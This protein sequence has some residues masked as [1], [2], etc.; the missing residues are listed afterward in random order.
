MQVAYSYPYLLE[1]SD[2]PG[3]HT[4]GTHIHQFNNYATWTKGTYPVDDCSCG[5]GSQGAITANGKYMYYLS[6]TS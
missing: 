5:K 3:C 1:K 2:K 6:W 4:E